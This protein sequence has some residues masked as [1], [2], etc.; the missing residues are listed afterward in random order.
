MRVLITGGSRGIGKALVEAFHREGYDV[1]FTFQREEEA[2]SAWASALLETGKNSGHHG[3]VRF[4]RLDLN[5]VDAGTLR[6]MLDCYGGFD[7]LIHNAGMAKD[8]PF[9]FMERQDW[10]S[11]TGAALNSFFELNKLVLPG[12]IERRRGRIITMVSVSG[13]AGNRGQVNYAAAKGALIA[14]SKSLAKEV[15]RSGILV[16]CISPGL[17]AT[18]MTKD[19]E[20]A[21]LKQL[22]PVGRMGQPEEVAAVALFLASDAAS[23]ITGT[24][25]QVNGGMYS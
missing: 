23:Y 18:D 1:A 6:Q 3:Q 13:E 19:L 2:A 17:I 22:V 21:S 7:V 5:A 9:Y 20:I 16:N 15:G 24:V 4:Y 12:M 14:A 10:E 11:V 25:L 8:G